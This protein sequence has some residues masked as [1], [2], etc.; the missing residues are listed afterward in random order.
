MCLSEEKGKIGSSRIGPVPNRDGTTVGGM[1]GT[2]HSLG[3][4]RADDR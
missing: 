2:F 3:K 1:R 4:S